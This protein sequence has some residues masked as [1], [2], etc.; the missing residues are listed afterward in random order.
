MSKC[1]LWQECW[2]LEVKGF[3]ERGK[4]YSESQRPGTAG[5]LK[6]SR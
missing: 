1:G 4:E 6:S 3:T 2:G 5:A